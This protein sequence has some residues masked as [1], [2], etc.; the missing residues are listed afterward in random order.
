M[1]GPDFGCPFSAYQTGGAIHFVIIS[2]S[3][4]SFDPHRTPAVPGS[5]SFFSSL[6]NARAAFCLIA[7]ESLVP[8]TELEAQHTVAPEEQEHHFQI[9][10]GL[11]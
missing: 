2:G 9:L 3:V 6:I 7:N 5:S 4:L 8:S 10:K 11:P 1:D